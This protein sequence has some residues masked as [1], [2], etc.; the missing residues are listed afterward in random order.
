MPTQYY[1]LCDTTN[2]HVIL[3]EWSKA[4]RS[5]RSPLR[6]AQGDFNFDRLPLI[7]DQQQPR[8]ASFSSASR[9]SSPPLSVGRVAIRK[10][11]PVWRR[12]KTAMC[13]NLQKDGKC[14]Y[15]KTCWYAHAEEELRSPDDL[16]SAKAL[17]QNFREQTKEK[18]RRKEELAKS[19]AS[20]ERRPTGPRNNRNRS[21][22]WNRQKA[23]QFTPGQFAPAPITMPPPGVYIPILHDANGLPQWSQ[24]KKMTH[25][26]NCQEAVLQQETVS[27]K[28]REDIRQQ[29]K[30]LEEATSEEEKVDIDKEIAWL[31]LSLNASELTLAT[32]RGAYLDAKN[33]DDR[34]PEP[35]AEKH[36]SLC[37]ATQ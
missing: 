32:K 6:R 2:E 16:E 36:D 18:E 19:R 31:K 20:E 9:E 21:R 37:S 3:A 17:E 15:G 23:Q 25:L 34:Q 35:I 27:I 30:K 7:M 33:M 28:I 14:Q 22:Q 1:T 4:L 12:L 13:K 8:S 11:E 26:W 10:H 24:L 5:G 29:E